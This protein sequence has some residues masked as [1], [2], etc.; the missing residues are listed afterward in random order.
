[1]AAGGGGGGRRRKGPPRAAPLSR[2][3]GFWADGLEYIAGVDETGR[4]P[5]AGPVVAAAV[6]LRPGVGIRGAMDS[7]QLSRE[8]REEVYAEIRAK[9]WA[10]GVGA[11]SPREIDR[12]NILRASHV[13]MRRAIRRL[14]LEPQHVLVDGLPVPGLAEDCTA[15]VGGDA[16]CQSIACASIVAKVVRDRLMRR[17]AERYPGYGWETNAGY[18]T[19]EHVAAI[20]ERGPT[21]HH[22]AT[23]S[24]VAQ[25][26]LDLGA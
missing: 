2:E 6:V 12:I 5:L 23:F 16:R 15:I 17:L 18:G 22:R 9:A 3:R 1:M 26:D 24:P 10:V 20:R 14:G 13:A 7:K 4:G 8:Q 19:P 21:P 11:A 25:L